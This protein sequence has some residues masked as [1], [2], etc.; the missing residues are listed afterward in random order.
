MQ[1]TVAMVL[2]IQK[3][4]IVDFSTPIREMGTGNLR[5]Y[6]RQPFFDQ[7]PGFFALR[8]GIKYK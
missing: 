1:Y 8:F 6:F 7:V 3:V 4:H 5:Y 2:L